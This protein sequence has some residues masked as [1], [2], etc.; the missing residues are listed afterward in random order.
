MS[1]LTDEYITN[2][3]NSDSFKHAKGFNII[4]YTRAIEAAVFKE[5]TKSQIVD[6]YVNMHMTFEIGAKKA[7][8]KLSAKDIMDSSPMQTLDRIMGTIKRLLV[9]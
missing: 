1:I 8:L 3:A 6:D 7:I 5:V 2:L 4:D 9:S